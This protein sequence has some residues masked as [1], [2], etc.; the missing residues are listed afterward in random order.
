MSKQATKEKYDVVII[1]AGMGGLTAGALLSR[2]GLSVCILEKNAIPGGY[3][4]GFER[5]QFRFD[6][7][8]HW[9]NQCLP[10]GITYTIFEA[11]GDDY[12]KASPQKRVK[13]FVGDDFDYL[14]T[15]NP[16]ELKEELKLKFPHEADGID[17]F[18]V[19][20]KKIG[21]NVFNSGS[22][23]RTTDT[24]N[25]VEKIQNVVKVF[26]FILPFIPHLR[27]SGDEGVTKGLNR[28][29]KDKRIHN[30][31]ASELDMMSCII[32]VAWAYMSDYQ[33]PPVGGGQSFAEWL[34]NVITSMGNEICYHADVQQV[35]VENG[36]VKGV[37]VK[38]RNEQYTLESD[39]V[40][41][42]CDI[43]FLY[44]KLLPPSL[45]PVEFLERFKTAEMYSS[46]FTI[47]VAIKKPAAELGFNEEMIFISRQDVAKEAHTNGDPQTSEIIILSPSFRDP[48]MAPEGKGTITVFMPAEF[49]QHNNWMA[50][51]LENGEWERGEEYQKCKT[52]VAEILLKRIAEKV[53]PQLI[54][55]IE[56]IDVA[57]PVTHLRYSGNKNGTMMGTRPGKHNYQS[58]VAHYKTPV[59][60]LIMSGHWAELGGGVPIAAKAGMNAALIAM[61]DLNF[62]AF[63]LFCSYLNNNIDAKLLREH[64]DLISY[65]PSWERKLTPAELLKQRRQRENNE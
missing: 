38:H 45:R 51:K 64:K 6:T 36:T 13:R 62:N 48:T 47:N 43:E 8:I 30:L 29:F 2:A 42:A 60:N 27:F 35:L 34:S 22:V 32:P 9:L 24:M 63:K 11:I 15:N 3:L 4:M 58:K 18:F 19:M 10:G 31:F 52:E 23:I 37:L 33:N 53:S 56:F 49:H 54:E 39:F 28:Y 17:R 1:G 57:T 61:K 44:E 21:K 59:K 16:D 65:R 5:K 46:S 40:L 12:P 14:L 41:A 55:N 25:F 7:A 50:K 20:A 26:K